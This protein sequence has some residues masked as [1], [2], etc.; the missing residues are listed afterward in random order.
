[1]AQTDAVTG[2]TP[3]AS[4]RRAR[5]AATRAEAR[6]A[7]ASDQGPR[8]QQQRLARMTR[9][10]A[11]VIRQ[12]KQAHPKDDPGTFEKLKDVF[13]SRW[14]L[15]KPFEHTPREENDSADKRTRQVDGLPPEGSTP[16]ERFRNAV[17]AAK[18]PL[19][20]AQVLKI[21]LKVNGN[22]YYMATLTAHN[23][24]KDVTG[25]ERRLRAGDHEDPGLVKADEA[26]ESRLVNL[27]APGDPLHEDKMGPWYHIFCIATIDAAG[28]SLPLPSFISSA[29][30]TGIDDVE[31]KVCHTDAGK[32][33]TDRM[34][35][36]AIRAANAATPE[37]G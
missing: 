18:G 36:A 33:Q 32:N 10:L 16:E 11:T 14:M 7:M 30:D 37:S 2:G 21:A 28:S 19:D 20:P 1:M 35:L 5:D 27:R 6:P 22:D 34:M 15:F 4:R 17:L 24:L 9:A 31:Q 13:L 3:V 12:A 29:F 25:T 23:V 8:S 26:V